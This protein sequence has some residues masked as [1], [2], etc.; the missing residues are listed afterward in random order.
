M[1]LNGRCLSWTKGMTCWWKSIA[2]IAAMSVSYTHLDVYKR[3]AGYKAEQANAFYRQLHD[4]L[5]AMPGVKEVTY[6]IYSPM[7]GDNWGEG[8][9]IEGQAPPP[10]GSDE[11]ESSWDRVSADYFDNIGTKI[12]AGRSITGQDTAAT[13]N[14]A[15]VNQTFARHFFKDGNPIGQHFG[16][17]DPKYAGNFEIVGVTEDTQYWDPSSHIRPMFFLPAMQ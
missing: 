5:A 2:G 4:A 17:Q 14:V 1:P 7:E 11:N 13:R 8:I 9:W 3:Q 12:I 6:S 10:P 15:V 16:D